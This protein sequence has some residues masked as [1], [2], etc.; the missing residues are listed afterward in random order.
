MAAPHSPERLALNADL[1]KDVLKERGGALLDHVVDP[2]A[3]F[4]VFQEA[5][6]EAHKVLR[7]PDVAGHNL[8][9]RTTQETRVTTVAPTQSLPSTDAGAGAG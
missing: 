3:G 5:L 4:Q 6:Q 8:C 2:Q 1:L 9:Q 7:R